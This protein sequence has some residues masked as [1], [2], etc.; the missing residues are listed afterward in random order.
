[1]GNLVFRKL[2]E[3]VVLFGGVCFGSFVP[4]KKEFSFSA[5]LKMFPPSQ[6]QKLMNLPWGMEGEG[7]SH[8]LG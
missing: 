8:G 6:A 3:G 5:F 2:V 1:M 4:P 7:V